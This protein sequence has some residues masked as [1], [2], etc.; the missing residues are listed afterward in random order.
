MYKKLNNNTFTDTF[1]VRLIY[2]LF[3]IAKM[4]SV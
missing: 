2:N 4:K 1:S 3:T